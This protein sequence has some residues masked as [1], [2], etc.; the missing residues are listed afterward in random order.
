MII[1]LFCSLLAVCEVEKTTDID[2]SCLH[3]DSVH[4]LL[5]TIAR[6]PAILFFSRLNYVCVEVDCYWSLP[7]QLPFSFF[8]CFT[9]TQGGN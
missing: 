6:S 1:W 8:L 9:N 4:Q 5:L 7:G 3:S 2:V